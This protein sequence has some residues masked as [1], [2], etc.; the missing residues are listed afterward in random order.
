M[1]DHYMFMR[2]LYIDF[3]RIPWVTSNV[4]HK[5]RILFTK[6]ERLHMDII[7]MTPRRSAYHE[8]KGSVSNIA[9]EKNAIE[10]LG[11][12]YLSTNNTSHSTLV[13]I[14]IINIAVLSSRGTS[15]HVKIYP[16]VTVAAQDEMRSER[17]PSE[18][19]GQIGRAHV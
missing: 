10:K 2:Y 18:L 19:Y 9:N 6:Q 15:T 8:V 11:R 3:H 16:R 1:L 4:I 7:N 5:N 13:L 17:L 12:R 14:K